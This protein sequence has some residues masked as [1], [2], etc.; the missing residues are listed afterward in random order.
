MHALVI[1]MNFLRHIVSLTHLLRCFHDN[2]SRPGVNK[3][4]YFTIALV[5][6][7]FEKGFHFIV[8]LLV[9]SLSKSKST[10][11]LWAELKEE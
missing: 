3:L 9:I 1:S 5:N 8:G 4:L 7:S 6:S 11:W 2:L 10:L